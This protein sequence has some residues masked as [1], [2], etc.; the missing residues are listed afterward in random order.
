MITASAWSVALIGID[1]EPVEVEVAKGGGLPRIALVG[2]PDAALTQAKERVRAAVLG[3]GLDWHSGLITIN[4]TPANLPKAGTHYDLAIAVAQLAV[5]G[6]VPATVTR[7]HVFW[8]ELG[9]DGRVRRVPGILPALLAAFRAGFEVAYVPASQA[10]EAAL[11]PGIKAVPLVS[12]QE[13]C[14][15]LRGEIEETEWSRTAPPPEEPEPPDK[16]FR[17]VH[18]HAA[19]RWAME[20]AAAGRHHVFL[21]GAPGV[22]KTMLASRLPGILPALDGDEAVE[23]S[24]LHSL[25][26]EDLSSGLLLRPPYADPH[27]SSTAAAIIGGGARMVRPGAISLAHRGVLFLDEAP[28][29]GTRVL[30]S[31]R[32][33]LE[34][35]WVTIGRATGQV[36]YPASF[37]LVL[38][39]NP[40]P[41]GFSGVVGKECT[42]AP[43]TVRRYQERITGPVMDRIDIR[44]HMLPIRQSIVVTPE[45][46]PESSAAIAERVAEARE[47]QHRRLAATPWRTNGEVPGPHLR[48]ELPLP[49][50][51]SPLEKALARGQLSARGVD[52]VLRLAWT[53]SDLA[54]E[55]R[56]STN[57]L[58]IAMSMRL[59]TLGKAA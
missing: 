21:H 36:R 39:A 34:S 56:I 28:E 59:G 41:C 33:P 18:G 19:G 23:V 3:A 54:R 9:L 47:R 45:S 37:Q 5:T 2:L 57:S 11:V 22:G 26:G 12:L 15:V 40:C 30:D 43:V 31:L 58:R 52:K 53:V 4:L 42:C 32:T 48:R 29:F 25:A 14:A 8:G 27:H 50:D 55:D 7:Q 35:G 13:L 49:D 10:A 6:Q 16:D 1:G 46:S 17:D 44:H 24:A 38:A 51:I 20:V